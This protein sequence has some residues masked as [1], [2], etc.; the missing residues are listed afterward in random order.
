MRNSPSLAPQTFNY[1]TTVYIVLNDYGKL[2]C[3]YV[4]TDETEAHENV[5][6]ADIIDGQYSRPTRVIAFNT[7][8][9]WSRD[10]SE[11]IARKILDLNLQGTTLSAP[12]VEFVGRVTGESATV[13]V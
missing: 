8:Q 7:H 6:V 3:A 12:A 5:V 10:V 13:A 2:V 11:Q 1:D 4:E 9:G